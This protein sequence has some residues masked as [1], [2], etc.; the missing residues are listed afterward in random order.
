MELA[1]AKVGL[2]KASRGFLRVF[3][4]WCARLVKGI[5]AYA[6]RRSARR[7]YP[8]NHSSISMSI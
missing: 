3:L 6:C 8:K 5:E 2:Y 4:Q 7:R 1:R